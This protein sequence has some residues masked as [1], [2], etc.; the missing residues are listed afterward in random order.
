MLTLFLYIYINK[1][2]LFFAKYPTTIIFVNCYDVYFNKGT[3][4]TNIF[5]SKYTFFRCVLYITTII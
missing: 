1:L 5:I 4:N 2:Q 3:Y